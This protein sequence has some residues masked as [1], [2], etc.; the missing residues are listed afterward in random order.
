M[1][2]ISPILAD[3]L[4]AFGVDVII[5]STIVLL[6]AFAAVFLLQR[7]SAALRHGVWVRSMLVMLVLPLYCAF[8]PKINSPAV[9]QINLPDYQS[10]LIIRSQSGWKMSELPV[11]QASIGKLA[12]AKQPFAI[13]KPES[14]NVNVPI[15]CAIVW[16]IGFA[17]LITQFLV[18][19]NRAN[20]LSLNALPSDERTNSIFD[21]IA[22]RAKFD[23]P[24]KVLF[25]QTAPITPLTWGRSHP[26]ILLPSIARSWPDERLKSVLI[27]EAAHIKRNDWTAQ[28]IG[29]IFCA[30]YWFHPLA[31][32][33]N[34]M[35]R[36]E[37]ELACDD[38]VITTGVAPSVYSEALLNIVKETFMNT[39]PRVEAVAMATS[40]E[41]GTR[42]RAILSKNADRRLLS[43]MVAGVIGII[44]VCLVIPL[45]GT[46]MVRIGNGLIP[47]AS[48][49][50][51]DSGISGDWKGVVEGPNLHLVVHIFGGPGSYTSTT[52]STDQGANGIPS[53]V[54]V[55][56]S[57]VTVSIE[58]SVP[59]SFAGTLN[60]NQIVGKWSQ[61]GHVGSMTL[62]NVPREQI[63]PSSSLAGVWRGVVQGPNL[64]L[65][66]HISGDAG[67]YSV[68]SDSTDQGAFKIP[69]TISVEGNSVTIALNVPGAFT[70]T[71]VRDGNYLRGTWTQNGGT[72]DMIISR[73]TDVA[74]SASGSI[75][76]LIG[77]WNGLV[78]G[79]NLHL[80]FHVNQSGVTADSVDQ[81]S[82]SIPSEASL[83]GNVVTFTIETAA[84]FT[85]SGTKDGDTITG[86]WSQGGQTGNM[87]LNKG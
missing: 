68:T 71:G 9:K 73:A 51:T 53:I 19:L 81:K 17:A 34:Y 80:V 79:P 47:A 40:S 67:S 23:K 4:E 54:S 1:I 77:N 20:R 76:E 86:K 61:G 3:N 36:K 14:D 27:H 48:A 64:H 12:A 5:T 31:W 33:A 6:I 84:P 16:L 24:V 57:D 22:E 39:T 82:Y 8:M 45:S 85:F 49:A 55:N 25:S 38:V 44:I 70:F 62:T 60:G 32:L 46:K 50:T 42:V 72:G 35:L 83:N 13:S 69:S 43:P 59:F 37:A 11:T 29:S 66:F 26:I 28:I 75:S 52:D 21:L 65:V 15:Y 10:H 18:G 30:I 58:T 56:G 74:S 7:F 41:L 78:Q 2:N 87:I 63:D